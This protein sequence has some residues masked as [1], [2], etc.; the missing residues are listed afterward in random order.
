MALTIHRTHPRS[1]ENLVRL[2]PVKGKGIYCALLECC[3]TEDL[4]T[5]FLVLFYP[6]QYE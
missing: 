3:D 1:T 4:E 5:A 6:K 2:P